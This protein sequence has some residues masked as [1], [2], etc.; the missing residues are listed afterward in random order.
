MSVEAIGHWLDILNS[1]VARQEVT[2]FSG[3]EFLW[4]IDV[5]NIISFAN[6]IVTMWA[7]VHFGSL[8]RK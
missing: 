6:E 3:R 7:L 5:K 2:S 8:C 4:I 1:Q